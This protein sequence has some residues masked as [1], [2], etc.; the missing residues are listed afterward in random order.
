MYM[1]PSMCIPGKF[2]LDSSVTTIKQVG[3][4]AAY[5]AII[6]HRGQEKD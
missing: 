2:I 1:E 3:Q 6:A 4:Y 5:I